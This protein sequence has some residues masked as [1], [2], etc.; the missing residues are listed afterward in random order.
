MAG[1][2]RDGADLRPLARRAQIRRSADAE[3]ADA[4]DVALEQGVHRLGRR[5]GDERDA[6]T[7][8]TEVGE[9]RAQCLGHAF[10]DAGG[11]AV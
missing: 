11:G 2:E 6:L 7:L 4:A 3:H 9:Q 10:G 5:E 8:L 1:R